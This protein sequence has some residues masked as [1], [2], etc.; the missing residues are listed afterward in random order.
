MGAS[1]ALPGLFAVEKRYLAMLGRRGDPAR[2]MRLIPRKKLQ[3]FVSAYQ[4]YLFNQVL[5]RRIDSIHRLLPG[6]LA[7]ERFE[8]ALHLLR[9]LVRADGAALI[10]AQAT[11][12]GPDMNARVARLCASAG[13]PYLDLGP[14]LA[15][16]ARPVTYAIDG[17]WRPAGHRLAAHALAPVVCD[18]LQ[19]TEP[20]PVLA[21]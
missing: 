2:A 18:L 14:A 12:F 10:L 20:V 1:R 13:I 11:T 17:H 6:D 19:A 9:D 15:R 4:S 7:W 21:R 8:Q 3:F 16:S 5:S